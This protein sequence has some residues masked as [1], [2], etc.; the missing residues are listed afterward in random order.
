MFQIG[1]FS[2]LAQV[3][4]ETL[5][6]YD[7]LG[8]LP[9]AEINPFTGYRYYTASQLRVVQ[10]IRAYKELGFTLDEIGSILRGDISAAEL[11]KMLRKHLAEAE[12]QVQ[13][14][15]QKLERVQAHLKLLNLEE[16]M[17]TFDI[18][19]KE[20]APVTIAA[21]RQVVPEIDDMPQACGQ[22]FQKMAAWLA[23]NH[24]PIGTA[25][26]IYHDHRYTRKNIDT[27]CGF[28]VPAEGNIPENSPLRQLKAE[29]NAA[30]VVVTGDFYAKV[31]GLTPAYQA[32][33]EWI[34]ANGYHICGEFRELFHGSPET[35]DLTAEIQVP[36][37]K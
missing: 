17:P 33:A 5:R 25:I 24:L 11:R 34:E 8:L 2:R 13:A 1:E 28:I 27:E 4:I 29:N 20:L 31:D 15:A 21:I 26:T 9:P 23:E 14:M 35:G 3:T 32:L 16:N 22:M 18:V 12:Q 30:S 36:V 6:H 19:L 37:E 10:R 7:S